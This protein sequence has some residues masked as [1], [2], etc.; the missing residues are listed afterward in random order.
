MKKSRLL[1]LIPLLMVIASVFVLPYFY[2]HYSTT[3]P[4]TAKLHKPTNSI[5][6][7]KTTFR[8]T[9]EEKAFLSREKIGRIYLRMFDVTEG[10][11]MAVPNATIS[12]EMSVPKDVEI[13]P[14]VFIT[15]DAL[16][17]TAE[18]NQIG[19]LAEKIVKRIT[20]MCSWN[21]ITQWNE[22]QLDCDW[23]ESTRDAFYML[24]K[25]VKQR[26]GD[27]LL[28]STIRL[29][30]LTQKA[31]PV[32]YGV[33]M[34]YNT[35][36]F[37]DFETDN[38]ILNNSTVEAYLNKKIDFKLPLDVA[39]PIYQWDLVFRDEKFIRI[40]KQYE[41]PDSGE[42]IRHEQVPIKELILTQ[43]LLNKYLNIKPGQHSTI[44]YYLDSININNYRHE[45]I[46]IIYNN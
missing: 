23:T 44:L 7:W 33:L 9:E 40:A 15:V 17:Q 38:S 32:D 28:S 1:L 3:I 6:Y 39:L 37:D 5:Y 14:T 45:H 11:P 46:K 10:R 42:S 30:Q 24:C 8:L 16:R 19:V 26:C 41:Y 43:R 35:D 25:E 36:R 20:A 21:D 27:K 13:V 22:I 31:P 29:H 12:F 4:P 34:M 2:R 18:A